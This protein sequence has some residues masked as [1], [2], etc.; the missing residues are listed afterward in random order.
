[1]N[2]I[3]LQNTALTSKRKIN[4]VNLNILSSIH[5]GGGPNRIIFHTFFKEKNYFYNDN[6]MKQ[7]YFYE[8]GKIY[9]YNMNKI[10]DDSLVVGLTASKKEV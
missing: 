4:T 5:G 3:W 6:K 1:M 7:K 2:R 9:L 8:I 10:F